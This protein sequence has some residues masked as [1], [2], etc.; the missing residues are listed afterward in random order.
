MCQG[1]I[2]FFFFTFLCDYWIL[3]YILPASSETR[4]FVFVDSGISGNV[5]RGPHLPLKTQTY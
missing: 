5:L 3:L 4:G 1:W 2:Y